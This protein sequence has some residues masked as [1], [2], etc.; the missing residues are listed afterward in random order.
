MLFEEGDLARYTSA[1]GAWRIAELSVKP[2]PSGRASHAAL[3]AVANLGLHREDLV[4]LTVG[5]PPLIRHLVDRP[6]RPEMTPAYAKI[7]SHR[8]AHDSVLRQPSL[9]IHANRAKTS[10]PRKSVI[11]C[12]TFQLYSTISIMCL[13][14][15]F[16]PRSLEA[17]AVN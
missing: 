12:A 4:A 16:A 14:E 10:N 6:M 1:L 5:M 13:A 2:F 3:Q 15:L 8:H 9:H 7:L 11:P 17:Q